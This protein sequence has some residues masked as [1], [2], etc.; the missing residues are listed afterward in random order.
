MERRSTG[1]FIETNPEFT[2]ESDTSTC[3]H[4]NR[5][6]YIKPPVNGQVVVAPVRCTL[7]RARLCEECYAKCECDP[8]EK[9]MDREEQADRLRRSI[10]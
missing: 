6:S 4:C 9:K 7:C 1:Y 10:L 2:R 5:V 3:G 8:F